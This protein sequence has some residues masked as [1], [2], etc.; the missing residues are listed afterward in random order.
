MKTHYLSVV[1][2]KMA[3]K[4]HSYLRR[5]KAV[6]RTTPFPPQSG[7]GTDKL[8]GECIIFPLT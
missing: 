2:V 3:L 1:Y 6:A 5:T 4:C 7:R 8:Y